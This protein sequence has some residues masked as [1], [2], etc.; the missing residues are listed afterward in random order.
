MTPDDGVVIMGKTNMHIKMISLT[1]PF[2]TTGHAY[3]HLV[4]FEFTGWVL[5][6]NLQ[7]DNL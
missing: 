1:I 5:I 7:H 4:N 3:C 6:Q 2:S